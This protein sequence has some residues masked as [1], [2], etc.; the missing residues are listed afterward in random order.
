MSPLNQP[1]LKEK[2]HEIREEE[3]IL[4][5]KQT[6]ERRLETDHHVSKLS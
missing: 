6:V 3:T 4:A 1:E 2:S 5:I